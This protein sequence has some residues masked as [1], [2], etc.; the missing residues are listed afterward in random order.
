MFMIAVF[1]GYIP[2]KT[3]APLQSSSR[4]GA[5]DRIVHALYAYD[6]TETEGFGNESWE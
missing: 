4:D 6:E 2:G 5:D 3:L 1:V